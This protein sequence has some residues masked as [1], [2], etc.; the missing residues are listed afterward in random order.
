[1]PIDR[2]LGRNVR[3]Y[4]ALNPDVALGG[5]IQNGTVTEANFL[6]MIG[7]VLITEAPLRVQERASGHVVARTNNPLQQG[8]FDVYCDSRCSPSGSFNH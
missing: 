8:D 3:F 7:I 2:S 1:M 4:D 5:L 6:D